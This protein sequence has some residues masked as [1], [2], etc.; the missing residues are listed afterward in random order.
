MNGAEAEA[1]WRYFRPFLATM[2]RETLIAW[3]DGPLKLLEQPLRER[4]ERA[5]Y[6]ELGQRRSPA[7]ELGDG[8][9]EHEEQS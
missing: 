7:D 8:L 9:F 3:R 5:I 4:V 6:W 1:N 2:A